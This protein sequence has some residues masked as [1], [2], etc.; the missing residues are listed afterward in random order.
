MRR[1]RRR[2]RRWRR[3]RIEQQQEEE[4]EEEKEEQME[5]QMEEQ[6]ELLRTASEDSWTFLRGILVVFWRLL[7]VLRGLRQPAGLLMAF[8][9]VL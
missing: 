8:L 4:E 3:T 7:G 2:R 5:E 1:R 9:G 6:E